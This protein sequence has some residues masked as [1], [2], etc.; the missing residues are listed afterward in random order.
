MDSVF[1]GALLS[2]LVGA[3]ISFLGYKLSDFFIKKH[4]D[5]LSVASVIR[6]L[7]QVLYIVALFFSKKFL[8]WD[9][10]YVL[11][12]GVLGI[13]LPMI[14]FTLMLLKTNKEISEKEAKKDG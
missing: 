9:I 11:I 12:G 10:K 8:P 6:Q 7:F 4:P 5:K 1:A 3:A 2:F 14:A 13:T